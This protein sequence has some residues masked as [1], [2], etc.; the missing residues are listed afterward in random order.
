ME[1]L[2]FY[3]EKE[4]EG[5]RID[6]YL[7]DNIEDRSRAFIQNLIDE[8]NITVN[9]KNIKSNYKVKE[10]DKVKV[11]IPVPKELT[12]AG[13]DIPLDIVFEDK[14]VVVVNKPQGMVVH[15]ASGVYSGTLVN[16]LLNHCEDLS[17]INGV[18][19]PGIVHRIDKDTSGV[20][21]IAKNDFAHNK[22]AEQ[23]KEHSMKREYYALVEGRFKDEEG[24]VDA[25]LGRHPQDR[26]K[27][28]VVKDGKR[29]V[30]HYKV[31]ETY[32]NTSLIK[33]RLETG[34]T[35][36]IRVHMAYI[37]HPLVGDPVY[38]YKKQKYNLEGQMLHAKVL[39][40]VHPTRNEYME[41]E[42]ELPSYFTKIL[43][44]LKKELQ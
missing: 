15:P 44:I 23:F 10:K 13:E 33:C 21:V 34:R 6:K 43:E 28:A 12:I 30:T 3:V 40:F 22:L 38:G 19:R 39:G 29:A 5:T 20:L 31:I 8:N 1:E 2:M 11:I 36:Q 32:K 25:P 7:S 9:D 41:F 42:S 26:I 16:A 14:D 4:D 35:H 17:G 27:M 37:G 24:I 18:V